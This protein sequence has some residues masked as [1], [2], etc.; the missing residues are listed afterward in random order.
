MTSLEIL[1]PIV[2][3]IQVDPILNLLPDLSTLSVDFATSTRNVSE[4]V[5]NAE[6]GKMYDELKEVQLFKGI[7]SLQ[8]YRCKLTT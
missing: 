2:A 7:S 6:S 4:K 3:T 8:L 5:E 1:T